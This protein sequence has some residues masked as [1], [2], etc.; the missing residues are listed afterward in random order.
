MSIY[1]TNICILSKVN[2]ENI[3]LKVDH[4]KGIIKK[5]MDM[6]HDSLKGV[7]YD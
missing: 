6:Q 1:K 3:M 4:F 2:Y 7:K 5:Y